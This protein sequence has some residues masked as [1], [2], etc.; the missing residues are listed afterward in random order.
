MAEM[1]DLDR[2][3]IAMQQAS[4]ISREIGYAPALAHSLFGLSYLYTRLQQSDNA[5]TALVESGDWFRLMED[6]D[7]LQTV[8]DRLQKLD[9]NPDEME[10]PP[11]KMGWVKTYVTLIEGKVYC[12][13]ESPLARAASES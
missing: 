6:Q 3:I 2:A 5:R 11:A 13:Y 1:G 4:A 12:E 8:T 10:E 7:C 9:A